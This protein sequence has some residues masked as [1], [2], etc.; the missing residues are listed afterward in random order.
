[1][2][3]SQKTIADIF[4]WTGTRPS[5]LVALHSSTL[6]Q[7]HIRLVVLIALAVFVCEA[8]VMVLLAYL[9]AFPVWFHA[10]FDA[11]LLV[12]FLSP[13]LYFGLFRTLL[14]Y[15][16]ERRR[17]EETIRQQRDNL[18]KQVMA[19]TADLNAVNAMLKREIA[20]RQRVEDALQ[21]AKD[22]LEQRVK[23]RTDELKQANAKLITEI[24]ERI[25]FE[26]QLEHS[27]S[28]LQ[29]V[30]DGIPDPLVLIDADRRVKMLNRSAADYFGVSEYREII[31]SRCHRILRENF[32]PCEGCEVPAAI[33]S[34]KNAMFE[35]PGCMNPERLE[36][37]YV[38]PVK[39]KGRVTN[40][41]LMR[42]SDITEQR[43]FEKQ[44]VQSEK[45]ASLG[46]LVSSI[47]HEIN[48]PNSFISFNLPILKDYL[49]EVMPIVDSHA[50]T[51]PDLQLCHMDYPEF[52]KDI[53]NLLD[54]IAHGSERINSFVS[55]LKE[56]SQLK[57]RIDEKWIDLNRVVEKV[58]AMCRAQLKKSVRTFITNMSDNPP[59]I[60]SDPS[61]LEQILLNLLV[62][63]AQA[64]EKKDSRL[65]LSVVVRDSWLDHTILEVKDNGCGINQNAI[66][67]IFYPFFTTK[68]AAGG[69]GLGLYV[70]H[71]LV[72]SLRGRIDVASTP[73]EGSAFRVFL[74]DKERRQ[75]PRS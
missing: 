53:S 21:K 61:A 55:N 20:E 9:P 4:G 63:A 32:A 39:D 66:Q 62:N 2:K 75:K 5:A 51:H 57:D 70:T 24:E 23:D 10:L 71:N 16:A 38:Y 36:R 26:Q 12:V 11:T 31:G 30:F 13:V 43:L 52:R 59:R 15:M 8:L 44:L 68:S 74:P 67:K 65:E 54:N 14:K 18:D 3:N 47:A 27:K 7:P 22:E 25:R 56:F 72:E 1:M 37:V 19:R 29:A 60:W 45:M 50:K 69:T 40:D 17:A 48:N 41:V 28:M 64:A 73:G 42:I 34:G 33:S 35:R 49:K 6:I 46:V 58:L